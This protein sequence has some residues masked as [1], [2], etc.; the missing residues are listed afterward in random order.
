MK[1]AAR[2]SVV[3]TQVPN[4]VRVGDERVVVQ[5]D[6]EPVSSDAASDGEAEAS[7]PLVIQMPIDIRHMALSLGA[8]VAVIWLLKNTQDVLI[9]FVVSGM[10]FYALD[11]FVDRL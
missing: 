2:G 8:F 4:L 5:P 10:L 6:A 7:T 11:P 9:P 1:N 3:G